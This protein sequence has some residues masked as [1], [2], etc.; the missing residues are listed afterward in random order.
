[1]FA[2][3]FRGLESTQDQTD[4]Q[5]TILVGF[6]G[7]TV[8]V[9]DHMISFTDEVEYIWSKPKG[10]LEYLFILNR[11]LIPLGFTLNLFAYLWPD[12]NVDRCG[13]FVR[14][15]GSLTV[16]GINVVALMMLLRIK[17]LYNRNKYIIG[18]L[19]T[20]L[21]I[22]FAVNAWLLSNGQPVQHNGVLR[23]CTM[24]FSSRLRIWA[25][26]SA[27]LP[28]FYDT[29]VL[30]LTLYRSI[31]IKLMGTFKS[32]I[33]DALLNEGLRYYSVI[34]SINLILVIMIEKARPGLQNITAQLELLFTVAMMSRI[35][36]DFKEESEK[37]IKPELP[38]GARPP[39][40]FVSFNGATESQGLTESPHSLAS[41]LLWTRGGMRLPWE[42]NS[43]SRP[44]QVEQRPTR[45]RSSDGY[46]DRGRANVARKASMS[47]PCLNTSLDA[48]D[49]LD[50]V[51]GGKVFEMTDEP[52]EEC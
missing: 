24:I 43:Q 19:G 18:V 52:S 34:C 12:W 10:M 5:S 28:L 31:E 6:M 36:L 41:W 23:P 47:M 13:H 25:S 32:H 4:I 38:I 50:G 11:Y 42:L 44:P 48:S 16:I 27:W 51:A 1:M 7:Y 40:E 9:Y 2:P 15:E 17:K 30:G 22:E 45:R 8:L 33:M 37:V 35:T 14:Y 20:I 29:V 46:V 3:T 21:A 26:A 49:K 39:D